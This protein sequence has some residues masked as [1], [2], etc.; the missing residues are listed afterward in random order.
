L[1]LELLPPEPLELE[2]APL[3]EWWLTAAAFEP[4]PV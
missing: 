1:V 4:R 3:E 2:L